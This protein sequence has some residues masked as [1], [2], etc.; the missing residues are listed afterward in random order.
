MQGSDGRGSDLT[1]PAGGARGGDL[2]S[3]GG[4]HLVIRADFHARPREAVPCDGESLVTPILLHP[5]GEA[6]G[7]APDVAAQREAIRAEL[8]RLRVEHRDLDQAIVA[9]GRSVGD[10]LQLQR[11]KRRKLAL[12]DR[13]RQLEDQITPDIIA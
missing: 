11:L 4:D 1:G 12:R 7:P 2:L 8:E 13:I 5:E 10:Q 6:A 3:R 9:L